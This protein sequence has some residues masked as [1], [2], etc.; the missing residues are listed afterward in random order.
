MQP[1][2]FFNGV[3]A[4]KHLGTYKTRF[5]YNVFLNAENATDI[6]AKNRRFCTMDFFPTVLASIGVDIKGN[7]L[8]LGTDLFSGEK[9]LAEGGR[10]I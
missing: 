2:E 6:H 10:L 3:Q 8:G 1:E 5:V 9:N 4:D 7:R